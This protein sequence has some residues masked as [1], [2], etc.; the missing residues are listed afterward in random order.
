MRENGYARTAGSNYQPM[1]V[2]LRR[3]AEWTQSEAIEAMRVCAQEYG[4]RQ[5]YADTSLPVLRAADY[6][7]WCRHRAVPDM[8]AI[9]RLFANGWRGAC[10]AADLGPVVGVRPKV[11]LRQVN[12]SL[13]L[14][15]KRVGPGGISPA[16]LEMHLKDGER[17]TYA[18]VRSYW[19]D[20]QAACEGNGLLPRK[21]EYED[22]SEDKELLH[23]LD[24]M[25]PMAHRG[26]NAAR[27]PGMP[28]AQ[29]LAHHLAGGS[30]I[31]LQKRRGVSPEAI[32]AE[33]RQ[34]RI[35]AQ[36]TRAASRQAELQRKK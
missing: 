27:P 35:A 22:L 30:W 19:G 10:L 9:R 8:P 36:K 21:Q 12:R 23:K 20:W 14:L 6:E 28:T 17:I 18:E 13:K 25:L 24:Q 1:A 26:F 32:E 31:E 33:H 11:T 2:R 34:S 3:R 5:T 7:I 15:A 4:C 29:T 16:D